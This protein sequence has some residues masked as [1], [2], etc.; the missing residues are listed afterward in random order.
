MTLLG[1][2]ILSALAALALL[3]ALS[4][5]LWFGG[6]ALARAG[7][8]LARRLRDSRLGIRLGIR[9][10]SAYRGAAGRL[11]RLDRFV[12]ARFDPATITGL[13][14][15][16]L[17]AAA[18]YLLFLL[19]GI[20]EEILEAEEILRLDRRLGAWFTPLRDGPPVTL[21]TM[22]TRMGNMEAL[23]AVCLV[24]TAFLVAFRRRAYLLPL[25]VC[26]IGAQATTWAGKYAFARERPEFVTE[27]TAQSASFPS[28]HA[29]G[30]MAVYGFLAYAV[31]RDLPSS[32]A[33]FQAAYWTSV[34][35]ALIGLSRVA[36]SVHYASDVAAGFLVG[37]FWLLV[38]FAIAE[39]AR[40]RR[41]SSDET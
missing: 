26:V 29:A 17:A 13:P 27:V 16:L 37:G 31:A 14:L 19:G 22:I 41:F 23:V 12:R 1:W 21:F 25:W 15:T 40:E 11:P 30:A 7:I 4:Q 33:R 28:A 10:T 18:L 32:R 39:L 36:L 20:V 8:R 35:I 5:A 24:T 38:G 9:A 2:T 6:R 3:F 34:L